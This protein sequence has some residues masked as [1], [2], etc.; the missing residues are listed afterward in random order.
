MAGIL[1]SKGD[2]KNERKYPG[3]KGRRP[4]L[5]KIRREECEERTK[6]W[7]TLTPAQQLAELDRRGHAAKKQRAR[8][9]A[10]I[11]KAETKE[12]EAETENADKPQT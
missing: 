5:K 1:S 8:L 3:I 6:F 10:L 7:R 9:E 4:D 2:K 11:A 12:T